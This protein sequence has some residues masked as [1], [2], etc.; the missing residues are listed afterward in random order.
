MS[1]VAS[2]PARLTEQPAGAGESGA[3]GLPKLIRMSGGGAAPA[4]PRSFEDTGLD[5]WILTDLALK[6][7]CTVPHLTTQWAADQ[8]RLPPALVER[9]FYQLQEDKLVEVLGQVDEFS[10]RYAATGRG[11]EY[12]KRLMEISGYVGPAPVS[13][14]SYTA[15]LDWQTAQRTPPPFEEIRDRICRQLV[16]PDQAIEVAALASSSARSLFI[17]GP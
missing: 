9:I 4:A 13:L 15:L 17:S 12:A 10:Y 16:L 2:P 7:T 3:I 1:L 8:L 6:L 14:A 11:R 5:A